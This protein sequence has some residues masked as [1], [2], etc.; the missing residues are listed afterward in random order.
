LEVLTAVTE[1]YVFLG[2]YT[3]LSGRNVPTCWKN[4][5]PAIQNRRVSHYF[6]IRIEKYPPPRVKNS[7][8][9]GREMIARGCGCTTG[10][11]GRQER[12]K[13]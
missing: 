10:T 5:L 6:I 4:L 8:A 12:D 7:A 11:L 13:V 1:N 9:I 3:V 2:C